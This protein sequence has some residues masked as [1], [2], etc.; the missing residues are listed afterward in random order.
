MAY[1]GGVNVN[2]GV[3]SQSQYKPQNNDRLVTVE[4]Y[5]VDQ[6]VMEVLDS[7]N[8]KMHVHIDA[9]SIKRNDIS[10]S[11]KKEE[12]KISDNVKF[13]GHLIDSDME[14]GIPVGSKV[15][16]EKSEIV[17]VSKVDG[18]SIY[19]I[20]A[21]RIVNAP[22]PEPE[23]T[24][25][26]L[27]T[28][29]SWDNRVTFV[30]NWEET[31][32]SIEDD[33]KIAELAEQLVANIENFGKKM[34][35]KLVVIPTVGIQLHAI[36]ATTLKSKD[37]KETDGY[38]VIDTSAPLD[39]VSA[40]KDENGNVVEKGHPLDKD[41]FEAF[42]NGYQ[43][44]IEET[45]PDIYNDIK[46]EICKYRNIQAG[47][48][49]PYLVLKKDV[50]ADPITQL[51]TTKT[52]LA[53]EEGS[54]IV[55]KNWAVKGI[56]QLSADDEFKITKTQLEI[57]PR[58]YVT[59]LHANNLKGHVHSWIRSAD[60]KKCEPHE[61]LKRI[62]SEE[63]RERLAAKAGTQGATN[64]SAASSAPPTRSMPNLTD[65]DSDPFDI[66]PFNETPTQKTTAKM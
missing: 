41:T 40:V 60:G 42:V 14:R 4:K 23:K 30:Q 53:Q 34:H 28:L 33:D 66:D 18:K 10:F 47:S 46:I 43:S 19:V 57:I 15:I 55:G 8:R 64:N 45:F 61:M 29:S 62:I 37:G 31:A 39:W 44:Y 63:A 51:A 54:E 56:I 36:V 21:N 3:S 22:N 24:Y 58:N 32:I 2:K 7:E 35:E 26:G 13:Q 20:K 5:N 17:N 12:G 50:S 59:R 49:S 16:L 11:K 38:T 6:K 65:L 27:F 25:E 1:T 9:E 48:M 52:R